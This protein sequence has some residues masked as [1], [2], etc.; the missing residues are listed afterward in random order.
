MLVSC[1]STVLIK[2]LGYHVQAQSPVCILFQ[3]IRTSYS[4]YKFKPIA[5]KSLLLGTEIVL[6]QLSG[7]DH[8][9]K[10]K[11]TQDTHIYS[12]KITKMSSLRDIE[13]NLWQV[14]YKSL[15]NS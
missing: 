4:P 15:V 14:F 11:I 10:E 3:N 5:V 1:C 7:T 6:R 9:I 8:C 2:V 12:Q 13:L